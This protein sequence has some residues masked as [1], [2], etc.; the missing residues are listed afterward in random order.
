MT[1]ESFERFTIGEALSFGWDTMK[2]NLAF[3]V[4]ALL[5]AWVAEGIPNGL[6]SIFYNT[7]CVA[8][9]I[10]GIVLGLIGIVVSVFVYMAFTRIGLRFTAGET[11]DYADL[12]LS[13]PLF[14]K[15]LGGYIL[16]VLIVLGGL[17]LLIVPGIYWGIKYHFFAYFIIDEGVSPTEA[18]KRSSTRLGPFMTFLPAHGTKRP[19]PKMTRSNP[20]S[21]Y[22]LSH[23][24]V[25]PICPTCGQKSHADRLQAQRLTGGIGKIR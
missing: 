3:F 23:R 25:E 6:Q 19:W 17:I 4:L 11:A 7:D 5:I 20:P 13:Y 9:I 12:Y 18:L 16:Y 8:L 15:F 24:Q 10:P 22:R 1:T 2:N 14:W 21:R